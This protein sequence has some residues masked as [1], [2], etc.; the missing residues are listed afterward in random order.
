[1]SLADGRLG[2]FLTCLAID[3]SPLRDPLIAATYRTNK[4]AARTHIGDEQH[5]PDEADL[6][7]TAVDRS[8]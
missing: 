6:A 1:M 8:V 2:I 5:R 7:M 3:P 4:T